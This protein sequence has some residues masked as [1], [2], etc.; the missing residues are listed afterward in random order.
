[1]IPII[2]KILN[3]LARKR[4]KSIKPSASIEINEIEPFVKN[5]KV[6]IS[7]AIRESIFIIIG[8]F[9][10]GFGLKGFLLPNHFIDGGA[11]GISLLLQNTTS[12]SLG[13]LDRKSTR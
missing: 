1:M 9:S 4:L 7:H 5:I 2:S 13:I 6:E 10:A 3:G 11:T 8:V 12:L